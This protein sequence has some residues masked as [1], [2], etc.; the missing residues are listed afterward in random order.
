[1]ATSVYDGTDFSTFPG[2]SGPDL[3][4]SF[5]PISWDRA[6]AERVV[7]RWLANKG[8]MHDETY[9]TGI[10]NYLRAEVLDGELDRLASVMRDDALQTE[11]VVDGDVRI[12]RQGSTF[13]VNA[14]LTLSDATDVMLIFALD[15]SVYNR[16]S[17]LE[18][19]IG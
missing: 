3:D 13:A 4:P 1:M 8:S 17:L 9:G 2:G 19:S 14:A 12:A 7:R 16:I 18:I 11:G 10:G 6:V 15:P 5:V